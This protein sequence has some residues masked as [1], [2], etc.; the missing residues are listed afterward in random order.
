M[1][2][3]VVMLVVTL[4]VTLQVTRLA[5]FRNASTLPRFHQG[6]PLFEF[7]M[8]ELASQ[9]QTGSEPTSMRPRGQRVLNAR[10]EVTLI[11]T[12]GMGLDGSLAERIS[13]K[14]SR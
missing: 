14:G 3:L 6:R 1:V 7:P 8:A 2:T 12:A 5:V 9:K 10:N 11:S 13:L 4:M